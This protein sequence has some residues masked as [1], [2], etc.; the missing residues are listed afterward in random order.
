M[1]SG[2]GA[3]CSAARVLG[4]ILGALMLSGAVGRA[5]M[6]LPGTVALGLPGPMQLPGTFGGLVG[7]RCAGPG[8]LL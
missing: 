8:D 3:F 4:W 6:Y 7:A 1:G 2:V 5:P